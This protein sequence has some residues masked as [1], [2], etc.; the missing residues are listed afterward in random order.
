MT[1]YEM[2]DVEHQHAHTLVECPHCLFTRD[3]KI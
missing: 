2:C 3:G 1:K